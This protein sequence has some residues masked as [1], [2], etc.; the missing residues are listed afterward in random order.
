ML[1]FR[2]FFFSFFNTKY[3]KNGHIDSAP[4]RHNNNLLGVVKQNDGGEPPCPFTMKT[5]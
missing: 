3:R 4:V 1:F 5:K 2:V